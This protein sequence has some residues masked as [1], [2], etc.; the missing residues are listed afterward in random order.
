[1]RF[2][3]RSTWA[4]LL[5][6][7]GALG[8]SACALFQA[9]RS[10]KSL[11]Y[12]YRTFHFASVDQAKTYWLIDVDVVNPNPKPVAVDKMRFS[13]LHARDTLVTAWNPERKELAPADSL[14]FRTTLEIPHALLQRLPP[15]LL[16]D[17]KA[18]FT[19]VGDAYLR[20]WLGEVT[21]P[22]ALT[23]TIYVNMPEQVNK[24][25]NLFLQKMFPGFGKPRSP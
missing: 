11:R 3:H 6:A 21:I 14:P 16:A 7:L 23:Q 9:G 22:G 5:L 19:L 20:T 4:G 15:S 2:Q 13:L 18:E 17:P 12:H 25:R 24:V 8:L 10:V 1:M